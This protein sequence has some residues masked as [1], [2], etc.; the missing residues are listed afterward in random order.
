MSPPPLA[1]PPILCWTLLAALT[2]AAAAYAAAHLFFLPM[3]R[4]RTVEQ[5]GFAHVEG[6]SARRKRMWVNRLRRWRKAGRAPPPYPNGWYAIFESR[7]VW[8][9]SWRR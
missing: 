4:V 8:R 9:T 3:D 2:L 5:V 7:Q 6:G 1:L